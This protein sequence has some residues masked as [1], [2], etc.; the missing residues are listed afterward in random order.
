MGGNGGGPDVNG[1]SSVTATGAGAASGRGAK[2]AKTPTAVS[3]ACVWVTLRVAGALGPG[4][5][6][7]R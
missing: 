6:G 1:A 4:R 2:R 7:A 5:A 3:A